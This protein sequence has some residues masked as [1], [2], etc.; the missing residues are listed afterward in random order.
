MGR[1]VRV[2]IICGMLGLWVCGWFLCSVVEGNDRLR[3]YDGNPNLA[4]AMEYDLEMNGGDEEKADRAKAERYYLEYLKDVNESFQKARV[5]AQLGALYA[6]AINRRLGEKPDWEKARMYFR[7]VLEVEPERIGKPTMR[8]RTM[9][10]S[11]EETRQGRIRERINIYEWL[12]SI[13]EKKVKDMWLPLIAENETPSESKIA[14]LAS[15]CKDGKSGVAG[16]ILAGIR[17][18]SEEDG[19]RFLS[20]IVKRFGGSRLGKAAMKKLEEEGI[21]IPEKPSGNPDV[22]SVVLEKEKTTYEPVP[23]NTNGWR[24]TGYAIGVIAVLGLLVWCKKRGK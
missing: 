8:T 7:K 23:A 24:V 2:Q 17:E 9:L 13:D 10:A 12:T 16:N 15:Y 3:N 5:Y 1:M 4:K 22:N 19:A 21:V 20:E 6:T 14:S 18:L 11:M